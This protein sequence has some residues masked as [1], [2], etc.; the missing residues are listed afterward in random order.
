M[1]QCMATAM[2]V[3]PMPGPVP[4][5]RVPESWKIIVKGVFPKG[6]YAKGFHASFYWLQWKADG[7]AL[8][9]ALEFTGPAMDGRSMAGRLCMSNM[10]V[11]C[12]AKVGLFNS[13]EVTRKF[14]ESCGRPEGLHSP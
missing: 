9:R 3:D 14:L 12:G 5:L 1:A 6:V 7:A 4:G 10:A 11:E 8:T 2:S 13:D